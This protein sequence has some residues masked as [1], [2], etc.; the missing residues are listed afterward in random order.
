[1]KLYAVPTTRDVKG[2]GHAKL[3]FLWDETGQGLGFSG[4]RDR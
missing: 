3:F 2:T 4:Q 1:M